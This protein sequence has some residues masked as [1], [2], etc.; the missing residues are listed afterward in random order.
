MAGFMPAIDVPTA[1]LHSALL[2]FIMPAVTWLVLVEQRTSQVRL[3]CLGGILIGLG[4]L[5][6]GL[7]GK[8]PDWLVPSAAFAITIVGT[9]LRIQSLRM[10]LGMQW[11][12]RTPLLIMLSV[13]IVFELLNRYFEAYVLRAQFGA[14]AHAVL[15]FHL[16]DLARRIGHTELSSSARWIAWTY[17]LVGIAQIGR[18]VAIP[19]VSLNN[20]IPIQ[21]G[22]STLVLTSTLIL[23]AV[24]SHLAFIGLQLDRSRQRELKMV[25]QRGREEEKRKLADQIAHLDRQRGLGELSASLGHELNQPLAT[26]LTT[27][28]TAKRGVETG[29]FQAPQ[30]IELL[31][32]VAQNTRRAS[33]IIDRIRGYIRPSVAKAELVDLNAVVSEALDLIAD[34]SRRHKVQ[35]VRETV[36]SQ[37]LVRGDPVQFT[38]ILLNMLRNAVEALSMSPLRELHIACEQDGDWATLRLRDTGP[39]LSPDAIEKIGSPFFSTKS[40][41]L[42]MG[43]VI[44]RSIAEHHGGSLT[45]QN[46]L[47]N[48]GGGVVAE[49]KLPKARVHLP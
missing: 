3:W 43:I 17:A 35:I 46:N 44:S 19:F 7:H 1:V 25:E 16:A 32:K 2:Y 34:E 13:M 48:G 47:S 9:L 5:L 45:I 39:G 37:I 8:V 24:V 29:Y 11:Q 26:I 30:L 36:G 22:I 14:L 23:S 41:G 10:D 31:E 27:V 18:L 38:Q 49:L 20:P 4:V 21:E 28:Q 6:Y 33:Q 12:Q 40:G 15:I 42:G